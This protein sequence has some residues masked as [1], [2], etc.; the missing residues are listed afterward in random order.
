MGGIFPH[1]LPQVARIWQGWEV[2]KI[3]H[4]GFIPTLNRFFG[5]HTEYETEF[6]FSFN[7]SHGHTELFGTHTL[8]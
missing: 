6:A 2:A 3:Q 8:Y 4:T 7:P 1:K 5:V